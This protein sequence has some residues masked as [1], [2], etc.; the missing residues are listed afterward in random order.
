LSK[1][2]ITVALLG[3]FIC[4][5]LIL[6]PI[7][8]A[9]QT[10]K[11]TGTSMF[12][13][14]SWEFPDENGQG[15]SFLEVFENSTGSWVEFGNNYYPDETTVID[16]NI[17]VGI[18]ISCWTAFNNTIMGA[19]S[20]DD[21]KNLQRHNVTVK[22]NQGATVFSQQN[23]TF[24]YVYTDGDPSWVY[25]YDVVLNFLPVSG[26]IYT[27]TVTYELYYWCYP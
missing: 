23:F 27:V 14:S 25:A 10:Q 5:M 16:W 15:I 8:P 2:K 1:R 12:V 13:I 21:G 19:S 24:Y 18:K 6:V 17:S 20:S 26:E 9:T 4:S 7:Q 11:E 22:D 3:L